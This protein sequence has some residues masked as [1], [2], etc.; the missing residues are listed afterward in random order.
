[1][2]SPQQIEKKELGGFLI[3]DRKGKGIRKLLKYEIEKMVREA[4]NELV[5]K[6]YPEE[7]GF[8]LPYDKKTDDYIR[9]TLNR[10]IAK[11]NNK[12]NEIKNHLGIK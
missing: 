4:L 1:M 12:L 11:H 8:S 6:D 10:E 9:E 5:I 7:M 2:D 3:D